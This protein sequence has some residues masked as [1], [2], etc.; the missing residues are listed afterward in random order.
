MVSCLIKYLALPRNHMKHD[1]KELHLS[2]TAIYKSR[3]VYLLPTS[4]FPLLLL[5][6]VKSKHT[7]FSVK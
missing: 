7:H 5:M 4:V 3:L 1:G 2:C 6:L